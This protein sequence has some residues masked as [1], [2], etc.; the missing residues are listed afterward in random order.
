MVSRRTAGSGKEEQVPYLGVTLKR[1]TRG[2]VDVDHDAV[3]IT[4]EVDS[5]VYLDLGHLLVDLGL[6]EL[7]QGTQVSRQLRHN[8]CLIHSR[9]FFSG[10]LALMYGLSLPEIE[11]TSSKK[12]NS[13]L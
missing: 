12:S 3:R 9:T 10:L 11:V 4:R 8:K 1:S 7:A 6:H 13:R 2:T 5:R